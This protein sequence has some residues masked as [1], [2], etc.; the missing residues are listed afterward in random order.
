M[1]RLWVYPTARCKSDTV[2]GV[3][4]RPYQPGNCDICSKVFEISPRPASWE[5]RISDVTTTRKVGFKTA[6][7]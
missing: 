1:M 4:G 5:S 2:G 3:C 7:S 6:V